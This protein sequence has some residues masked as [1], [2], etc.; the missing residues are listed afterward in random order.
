M[1]SKEDTYDRAKQDF[2][3]KMS[4]ETVRCFLNAGVMDLLELEVDNIMLIWVLCKD[5]CWYLCAQCEVCEAWIQFPIVN[6]PCEHN[7]YQSGLTEEVEVIAII[8]TSIA[9]LTEGLKCNEEMLS[10]DDLQ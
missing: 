4:D 7:N 2:L 1:N 8:P 6:H 3:K 10:S 9:E 5:Q